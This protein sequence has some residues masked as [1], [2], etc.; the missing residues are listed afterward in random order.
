MGA[1][2][3]QRLAN[4]ALGI[5]LLVILTCRRPSEQCTRLTVT[6]TNYTSYVSQ[7]GP[8]SRMWEVVVDHGCLRDQGER[9]SRRI[10][11]SATAS[12]I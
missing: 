5:D 1:R 7:N 8:E 9:N 12:T 6:I 10:A 4:L 11:R 3:L 2:F